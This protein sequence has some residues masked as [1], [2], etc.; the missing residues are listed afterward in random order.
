[1]SV[2]DLIKELELK[3]EELLEL[4]Y[5]LGKEGKKLILIK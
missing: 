3:P 2:N 4:L 5:K 1:M